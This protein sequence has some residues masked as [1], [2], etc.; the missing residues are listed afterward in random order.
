MAETA[1][2]CGEGGGIWPMDLPLD[3]IMQEKVVKGYL[4][5][6]NADGSPYTEEEGGDTPSPPSKNASKAEWVGCVVRNGMSPDDADAMTKN[7]LIDLYS[8][9]M[10]GE[11]E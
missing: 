9:A 2:Y 1:H 5:R 6:V 4:R 11:E 8:R 3:E 7:D 10:A